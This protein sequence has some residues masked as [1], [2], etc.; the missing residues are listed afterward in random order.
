[1][2]GADIT[3]Q[4][5]TYVHEGRSAH[6]DQR[7]CSQAATALSKAATRLTSVSRKSVTVKE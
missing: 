4:M 5:H 2:R 7:V 6:G 3:V 1:L